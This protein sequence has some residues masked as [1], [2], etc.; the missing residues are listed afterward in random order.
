[1]AAHLRYQNWMPEACGVMARLGAIDTEM[2]EACGVSK[3]TFIGW[4][5]RFPELAEAVAGGKLLADARVAAGLFKR[6]TGY[7]YD[8]VYREVSTKGSQEQVRVT[9]MMTKEVLPDVG[10][11]ALWLC[12]RRPDLW[13]HVNRVEHT[14][15]GGGPIKYEHD[16]SQLS[17][18]D[19]EAEIIR[20]AEAISRRAAAP[21]LP[22][23]P[24]QPGMAEE[25]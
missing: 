10:A 16:Y 11:I 14:G 22:L 4:K 6:A 19:L 8:E 21:S 17:D 15:D 20:E 7:R 18:A 3:K 23:E 2:A 5:R 13:R 25:E 24:P 1:M 9:K 12:N